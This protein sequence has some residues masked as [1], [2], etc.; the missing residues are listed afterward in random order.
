MEAK[1]KALELVVDMYEVLPADEH[2][3]DLSVLN[4]SAK[5]CASRAVD[6]ILSHTSLVDIKGFINDEWS[7][8]VQVQKEIEKL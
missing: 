4:P 3:D 2:L 8:W 6:E 5:K 7:Y 1:E